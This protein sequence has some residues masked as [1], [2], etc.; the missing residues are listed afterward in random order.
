MLGQEKQVPHSAVWSKP[1][2]RKEFQHKGGKIAGKA[3]RLL[4]NLS[5]VPGIGEN[6]RSN[7][8]L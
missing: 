5:S 6:Q 1:L 8:V 4:S 3:L 2:A 7:P